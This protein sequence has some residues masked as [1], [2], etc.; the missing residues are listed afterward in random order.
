MRVTQ[1]PKTKAAYKMV[2]HQ[3]SGLHEGITDRG[4]DKTK[5][6][7]FQVLAKCLR[8]RALGGDLLQALPVIDLRLTSNETPHI[9]VETAEFLLHLEKGLGVADGGSYLGSVANE[10]GICQQCIDFCRI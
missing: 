3:A 10:A 5:A 7:G 2:L 9:P 8:F 4:A 6:A 1:I